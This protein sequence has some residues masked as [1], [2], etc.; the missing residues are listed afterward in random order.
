MKS[1][2]VPSLLLSTLALLNANPQAERSSDVHR[3]YGYI[4]VDT[5]ADGGNK[6]IDDEELSSIL[7]GILEGDGQSP[8]AAI[9]NEEM[10]EQAVAQYFSII[11][12]LKGFDASPI[13]RLLIRLI[14]RRYCSRNGK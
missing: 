4:S 3:Q 2:F 5:K 10:Q 14:R 7:H 12:L 13:G 8:L 1:V 6:D 9:V 11:R